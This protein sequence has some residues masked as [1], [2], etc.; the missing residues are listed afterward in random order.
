MSR[1]IRNIITALVLA[2]VFLMQSVPGNLLKVLADEIGALLETESNVSELL[3]VNLDDSGNIGNSYIVQENVNRRTLNSKEYLMSDDTIMIQQFIKPIHYYEGGEYKEID[4]TLVEKKLENGKSVYENSNNTFKV[5]F[6][7]EGNKN[8]DTIEIEESGYGF[9]FSYKAKEEKQVI[10]TVKSADRKIS[11]EDFGEGLKKPTAIK[12][13]TGELTYTNVEEATGIVYTVKN[14]ELNKSI[15][16]GKPQ[17]NYA[18]TFILQS[19]NLQFVMG[20]DKSV[21]AT[22]KDGI[23]RFKINAPYMTDS[24]GEVSDKVSYILSESGTELTITADSEWINKA[25]LPVKINPVIESASENKFEFKSITESGESVTRG[26]YAY[27]GKKNGQEKSNLYVN[28]KLPEPSH[29]YKLLSASVSLGYQ[30]CGASFFNSKNY[31]YNVYAL[32]SS[33]DLSKVTQENVP[34]TLQTLNGIEKSTQ[35][36]NANFTYE[37][38]LI[39]TDKIEDNIITLGI[40]SNDATSD[41]AYLAVPTSLAESASITA[42][43]EQTSG[44]KDTY[45]ME[46]FEVDGSTAYVNNA[47]GDLTIASDVAS[48]NTMTDMPFALSLVYNTNYDQM[49]IDADK[50]SIVGYGFKFNFQQYMIEETG[51]GGSSYYNLI[52]ADGSTSIF[53]NVGNS[54]YYSKEKKLYYNSASRQVSDLLGNKMWFDNSGKLVNITSPSLCNG[55]YIQVNYQ[56][57][58]DKITT[59]DY[60]FQG[61][62]KYQMVFSYDNDLVDSVTVQAGSTVLNV[63]EFNYTNTIDG[64]T[65]DYLLESVTKKSASGNLSERIL[66]YDYEM[67][68]TN[69]ICLNAMFNNQKEGFGFRYGANDKI[70]E[71]SQAKGN[72]EAINTRRYRTAEYYYN[73]NTTSVTYY[74]N[75]FSDGVNY[76]AFNNAN[77]LISAWKETGINRMY[78]TNKLNWASIETSQS[79]YTDSAISYEQPYVI[80]ISDTVSGGGNYYKNFTIETPFEQGSTAPTGDYTYS[81]NFSIECDTEMDVDVYCESAFEDISIHLQYGGQTYVSI[82]SYYFSYDF[83]IQFVNKSAE[84]IYVSDLHYAV[85]DCSEKQYIYDSSIKAHNIQETNT[86][87]KA[88]G[89][90][91]N[92]YDDKQ[93]VTTTET[94]SI[95]NNEAIETTSYTYVSDEGYSKNKIQSAVTKDKNDNVIESTTY[96]YQGNYISPYTVTQVSTVDGMTTRT[97]SSVAISGTTATVIQTDENNLTTT[98]YYT[99]VGGDL[100]LSS[101]VYNGTKKDNEEDN[102]EVYKY[103]YGYDGLGRNENI[104][105]EDTTTQAT[106]YSQTDIYDENGM[107]IGSTVNGIEY[108][109][110]YDESGLVTNIKQKIGEATQTLTSYLYNDTSGAIRDNQLSV[111]TYANGN[112]E[113]YDYLSNKFEVSHY[114]SDGASVKDKYVYNHNGNGKITSQNHIVNGTTKLTYNYGDIYNTE[115]QTLTISGLHYYNATYTNYIDTVYNRVHKNTIKADYSCIDRVDFT[116]NYTYN[117]DGQV[118]EIN[119]NVYSMDYAYDKM[120]RLTNRSLYNGTLNESYV[121]RTYIDN[122]TVYTT[123][124]LLRI[125][126]DSYYSSNDRTT[127]YDDNGNI[128]GVRYNGF[129]HTYAYDKLGRLT[130]EDS[131]YMGDNTYTY[132]SNNNVLESRFTYN[133]KGQL[134]QVSGQTIVYDALG[135]PTTY[136]GNAFTWEQGRKLTAGTMD[137]NSFAY[138]YDGNGMR[139]KKVVN[140]K[141]TEYYYNGTQLLMEY[142]ENYGTLVYFYDA[143]GVAGIWHNYQ[144]YFFDKNTLGDVVAIRNSNGSIVATYEYDAWGNHIVMNA[145]G[146]EQYASDFI[147]NVNPFRYR[148]YYF[149]TETGFYYL[150]T[151]YYDPSIY[152]FINAD[153]Y[154]LVGIL[155]LS[156]ELN[157]YVYC[158]NNPIMCTDES[159]EGLIA[160]IFLACIIG[161]A[162]FGA[163]AEG[164][165]AIQNGGT[166]LEVIEATMYGAVKGAMLGVILGTLISSV[167]TFIFPGGTALALAGGG[168]VAVSGASVS[169]AKVAITAA[170]LGIVC[171]QWT[172]GSWPGDDPTVPPGDGFI[173]RGPGEVGSEFGEWYNPITGDQLHPDLNHLFPKGPHWGWKNKIKRIFKDIFR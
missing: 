60:Y 47:T 68:L 115:Q 121:Y 7:K 106:L 44:I 98:G 62:I 39:N 125:E 51:E 18:Y 31:S 96:N 166:V 156:G 134:T 15:V 147:G 58:S 144:T 40:E 61:Q 8:T 127:T 33:E 30:T 140:G 37:S 56:V 102:E 88:G 32:A 48:V 22:D 160:T 10:T 52:D 36:A 14:K 109:Y 114:Q 112:K 73:G 55:E 151:R 141:A 146:N 71:A 80:G 54:T 49:L 110:D 99:L 83:I 122:G 77:E 155:S 159:G 145:N 59:I 165:N 74:E 67:W 173:W 91:K 95:Y 65:T 6:D 143:T 87:F 42:Y 24:N 150:Q 131:F 43:Y 34:E 163:V 129:D 124:Q 119:F 75:G 100:R 4:N 89:Y 50:E 57:N 158:G 9:K 27:I 149:D 107:Y 41:N 164:V 133:N 161:T 23:V 157:M 171:S 97:K 25:S 92:T 17:K 103:N 72:G 26:D 153:D 148:S 64:E 152:R 126:D 19:D 132:D 128:I 154:E 84:R 2:V 90:I 136:K 82:P 162:V 93:R 63:Y 81:V 101:V 85:V 94:K 13:P 3:T 108:I 29:N 111:K 46:S 113:V 170:G 172:P 79:N 1:K 70:R 168:A 66:K 20:A 21:E 38:E 116:T 53:Q 135:N 117:N 139:Y 130:S 118:S 16:I 12:V 78:I 76:Y 169:L 69:V 35:T 167:A 5:K 28:F 123:N 138:T 105:V 11:T 137:G 86:N 45:S 104:T 142:R 120:G